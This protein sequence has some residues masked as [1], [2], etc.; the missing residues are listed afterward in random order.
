MAEDHVLAELV[1]EAARD[2]L[3]A[4]R[5]VAETEDIEHSYA[6]EQPRE[7][8]AIADRLL[9]DRIVSV[10]K[11]AGLS[12]LSEEAGELAGTHGSGERF[13]VDPLDGTVNFVRG[14][15]PCAVSIAL[16][17][18][19]EPIFGAI[20]I[21]PSGD[22]VWGGRDS[23]AFL[24]GRP[25]VVS[26]ITDAERAVLCTGFPTRFRVGRDERSH[27]FVGALNH[28]GKVRMLGSAA[29]SLVKVASGSA[30]L[31]FEREIMFWDVA[32]GLAIVEGA[33]GRVEMKSTE[34]ANAYDVIAGNGCIELPRLTQ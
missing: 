23:G 6:A 7:M 18:G 31:Y 30:D 14:L 22:L 16:C 28:Y 9:E 5:G 15:G 8:K 2:A 32:A 34:K 25:L 24:N 21:W 13:V 1:K 12:I 20:G 27:Q 10:L 26:E 33:G 11:P 17:S 19:C 3:S 4:L 29:V